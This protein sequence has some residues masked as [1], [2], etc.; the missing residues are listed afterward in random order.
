MK[1]RI[2]T[3]MNPLFVLLMILAASTNAQGLPSDD[4]RE[5]NDPDRAAEVERKAEAI[6]GRSLEGSGKAVAKLL[7]RR[8][9]TPSLQSPKHQR[10]SAAKVNPV[11]RKK[12]V[13]LRIRR[14]PCPKVQVKAAVGRPT[15]VEATRAK[16]TKAVRPTQGIP[17][18]EQ[19]DDELA[20]SG[21][22]QPW[23]NSV[24]TVFCNHRDLAPA[25]GAGN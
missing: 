20:A 25:S 4:V 15:V 10:K 19:Q 14:S 1:R 11:G 23:Q 21:K 6:S 13:S 7:K 16:Q 5:S 8:S 9:Q 17:T 18:T 12:V 24:L 22:V 2:A 3:S